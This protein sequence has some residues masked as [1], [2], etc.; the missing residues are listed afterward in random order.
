M[1]KKT[2]ISWT[3]STFNPW[4]GC[5]KVSPGCDHCYA[6]ALMD[7][8]WGQ[9]R[10]GNGQERR[11]T[12]PSNWRQPLVWNREGDAFASV[13]GGRRRRVF[14][15]SLADVFD[16]E[17]PDA[18]R[19]DLWALID[20][21][22][23]LDWLILTKRIGNAQRRRPP[24]GWPEHLWLG[25]TI[26]NDEEYQR[27]LPK[28][29]KIP[30]AFHWISVEPM[31][32]PI[33]TLGYDF[34]RLDWVVCGGES[35]AG[36]RPIQRAWIDQLR[37]DC[38]QWNVPFFFKQWGGLRAGGDALLDGVEVKAWPSSPTELPF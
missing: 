26:V 4:I 21:T 29:L 7:T 22:R 17:V 18:W 2:G 19:Q 15:A 6:G 25:A 20:Q 27:D 3:D 31:L 13:H 30:A 12:R 23:H 5:T 33:N 32:G 1:A 28:L 35:G 24:K 10:W 38:E 8:R 36:A 9:V 16:P 37:R 14:C 34:P 11:R